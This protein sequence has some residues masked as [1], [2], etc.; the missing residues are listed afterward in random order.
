MISIAM[1]TYNGDKY[2]KEQIDSIL[3]QTIQ[4]FEIVI[5][6]DCSTDGTVRILHEYAKNDKR[7]HIYQNEDNLGFKKNFEKAITLCKGEY[8]ALS[9][10]DDIWMPNH[11]ELL[12]N[13]I[14]GKVLSCGNADLIDKDGNSMGTTFWEQEAFDYIPSSDLDKAMSITLFRSPYQGAA[15]MI[16]SDLLQ[17]ALPIPPSMT[18][19]DSWFAH[20]ACFCGGIKCVKKS[21]L[22]YRRLDNSVTGKRSRPRSRYWQ[23]R[24]HIIWTN[25]IDAIR[26][27]RERLPF[28]TSKQ[29]S[30]LDIMERICMRNNTKK[31][32]FLNFMY[33]TI[34]YKT[35]YNAT[36]RSWK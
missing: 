35:I 2:I 14:K 24:N 29:I 12:K 20:I 7:F 21:I 32:R 31:G 26:T 10:Q 3:N 16:R 36:F 17:Y 18:Y 25:K 11:L 34:H 30:F 1:A 9:D 13:A 6:D 28:L 5:C 15:M 33:S 23:Y 22:K 8:I 27:I 19:H 4:D